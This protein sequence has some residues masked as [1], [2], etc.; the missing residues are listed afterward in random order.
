MN[1]AVSDLLPFMVMVSGLVLPVK[2]PLQPENTEPC[3]GVAV[4]VTAVPDL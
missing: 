4:I 2:A 3:A 1:I